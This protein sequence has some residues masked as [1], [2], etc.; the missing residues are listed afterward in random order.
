MMDLRRKH[1]RKIIFLIVERSLGLRLFQW[2]Q[3]LLISFSR[4]GM[5]ASL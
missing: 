5:E 3:R 1:E 2:D 4:N